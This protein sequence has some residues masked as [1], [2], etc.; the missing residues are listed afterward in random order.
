MPAAQNVGGPVSVRARRIPVTLSN[1][2]SGDAI[3]CYRQIE[4]FVG[5]RKSQSK[6]VMRVW[7]AD[8]RFIGG[9]NGAITIYI[10]VFQIAGLCIWLKHLSFRTFIGS[11]FSLGLKDTGG[12]VSPEITDGVP[13]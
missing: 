10:H 6:Y 11:N 3:G 12:L 8:I 13:G 9:R 5:G 1:F 7:I 4:I 2:I